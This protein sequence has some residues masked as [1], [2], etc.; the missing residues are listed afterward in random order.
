[1]KIYQNTQRA[2]AIVGFLSVMFLGLGIFALAYHPLVFAMIALG[3]SAWIFR[4]MTVEISEKELTWYFG[5]GWPRKHVLLSEVVSVEV[6]RTSFLNGWGIHY[7]PRG[8]LYNVSGFGAVAIRL[9]SGR[10]FCLGTDEPEE[11]ARQLTAQQD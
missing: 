5:P 1:M 2:T 4:S 11:L 7:T 9:R 6:I 8:W 10:Q 3:F